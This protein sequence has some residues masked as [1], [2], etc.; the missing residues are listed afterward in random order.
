MSK[1]ASDDRTRSSR[2]LQEARA[3]ESKD[4]TNT[5]VPERNYELNHYAAVTRTS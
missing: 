1:P 2:C 5:E 4:S 3:V